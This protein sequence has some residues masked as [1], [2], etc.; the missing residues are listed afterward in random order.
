MKRTSSSQSL[1][2][3]ET[4]HKDRMEPLEKLFSARIEELVNLGVFGKYWK[5][6]FGNESRMLIKTENKAL[7]KMRG[8]NQYRGVLPRV[9]KARSF[10]TKARAVSG[11]RFLFSNSLQS[12]P[13]PVDFI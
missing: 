7:T 12:D 5:R 1:R 4:L 2:V 6:V 8:I 9:R 13:T 3:T 10:H 11:P